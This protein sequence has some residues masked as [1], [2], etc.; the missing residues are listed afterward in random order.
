MGIESVIAEERAE[1][2][3]PSTGDWL[4][5]ELPP[6]PA[7]TAEKIR[8]H[9]GAEPWGSEAEPNPVEVRFELPER[10]EALAMARKLADRGLKAHRRHTSL[11]VFADNANQ[12]RALVK[13]LRDEIPHDAQIFYMGEGRRVI[14]I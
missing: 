10:D 7:R 5:V 8:A 12:A 1:R 9:P 13:R 6:L 3:D 4:N 2:R 11:F 14:F